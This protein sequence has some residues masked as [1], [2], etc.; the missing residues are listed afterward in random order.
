ARL[1]K[2]GEAGPHA[3][4]EARAAAEQAAVAV[5]RQHDDDRVGAREMRGLARRA[6]APPTRF[7][8]VRAH[9]AVGA[10]AV[11]RVPGE[12]RLRL[13]EPGRV[14][15]RA[16]AW[17]RDGGEMGD[18]QVG[19]RLQRFGR[20]LVDAAPDPR[21]IAGETEKNRLARRPERARL[22]G[23]EQRIMTARGLPGDDELAADHVD[24]GVSVRRK[25]RQSRRIVAAFGGAIERAWRVTELRPGAE[26][27]QRHGHSG[28]TPWLT[29]RA[30]GIK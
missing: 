27:W 16:R 4:D 12:Q 28:G 6:I 30:C 15:R 20:R 26:I 29:A 17:A 22:A 7:G 19:T 11:A 1:D 23:R 2:A 14:L 3:G 13:G 18:G 25:R 5:D 21:R 24:P 9:P 8:D 10:E